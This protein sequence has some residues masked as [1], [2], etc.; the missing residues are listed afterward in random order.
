MSVFRQ[1]DIIRLI[2][3]YG[4]AGNYL[5]KRQKGHMAAQGII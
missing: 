2:K 4:Y 5:T 1:K 3:T